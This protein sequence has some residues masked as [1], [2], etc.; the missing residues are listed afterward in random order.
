[1]FPSDLSIMKSSASHEQ[2]V[3]FYD[4]HE[5]KHRYF[6]LFFLKEEQKKG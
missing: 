6:P 2:K 3:L 1:M 4:H 5:S